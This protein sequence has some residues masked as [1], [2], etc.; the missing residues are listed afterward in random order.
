[1]KQDFDQY[2]TITHKGQL[3]LPVAFRRALKLDTRRKVRISMKKDGTLNLAPLPDVMAFYGIAKSKVPY[4]PDE[5]QIA[6]EAMGRRAM[7]PL[8]K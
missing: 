6:R 8:K 4:N 7:K 2:V 5:K 3:T 1:M